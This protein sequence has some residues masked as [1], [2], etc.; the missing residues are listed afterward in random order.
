MM[1]SRSGVRQVSRFLLC[2][3]SG[4]RRA[5]FEAEAVVSG[6]ENVTAMGEAVEQRSR[7]LRVAEHAGPFAETEISRDDDAGALVEFAEQMEE[8]RSAGGAE[9]QVA[10]FVKDD[11]VGIGE[12][13]GGL[14]GRSVVLFL[15]DGGD[16]C[17]R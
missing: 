8:Q 14:G 2:G 4:F 10:E 9:R 12:P 13:A 11:E 5:V 1:V 7:H 17:R 15:V 6:F 3:F 16:K